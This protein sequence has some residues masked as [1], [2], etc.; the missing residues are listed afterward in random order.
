MLSLAHDLDA[1]AFLSQGACCPPGPCTHYDLDE[2]AMT[3]THDNE[4]Y[5][6][7]N[8]NDI[9]IKSQWLEP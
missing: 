1:G 9:S 4:M 7:D 3:V 2:D 6:P 8:D 5:D